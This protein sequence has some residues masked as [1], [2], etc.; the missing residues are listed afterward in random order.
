MYFSFRLSLQ[1]SLGTMLSHGESQKIHIINTRIP[2][3]CM[4]KKINALQ[5]GVQL[6]NFWCK[7]MIDNLLSNKIHYLYSKPI[8][9][10][11]GHC[12]EGCWLSIH[13]LRSWI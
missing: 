9:I 5:P 6:S 4:Y 1:L 8:Q 11:L 13:N 3:Y 12:S 10:Q 7:I 2:R